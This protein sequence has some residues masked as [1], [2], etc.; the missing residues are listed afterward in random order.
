M[1]NVPLFLFYV[2]IRN[3]TVEHGEKK[4]LLTTESIFKALSKKNIHQNFPGG[5]V[6]KNLAANARD[7]GSIPGPGRFHI[8]IVQSLSCVQFFDPIDCSMPGFPVLHYLP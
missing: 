5:P 3:V 7:M 8:V 2:V 4:L 6:A 1:G